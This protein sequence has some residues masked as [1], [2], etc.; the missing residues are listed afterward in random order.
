MFAI[1]YENLNNRET[2]FDAGW[3]FSSDDTVGDTDA[4]ARDA[5]WRAVTIPHDWSVED[6]SSGRVENDG[7]AP[8]PALWSV[9]GVPDK[10]GPFDRALSAGRRNSGWTVGGVGWY[11]K[12]F[13]HP[14]P[15]TSSRIAV[16][17]DGVAVR[18]DIWINGV[19]LGGHAN[20]YTPQS[21]DL[22]PYLTTDS[23][24]VII[25]R[26]RNEGDTSRWYVGSGIYRHVW[27]T[28]TDPLHLP[29]GGVY[30]T[31]PTAHPDLSV[32]Q[33][34]VE[35]RND[36]SVGAAAAIR[37]T[38]TRP[39]GTEAGR[40]HSDP[41]QVTAATTAGF[42]VTIPVTH[43]Q[44]WSPDQPHLYR[45]R[46]EIIADEGQV[47]DATESSFGIRSITLDGSGMRINGREIVLRG[48][49][50]HHDHGALGA[51][52]LARSEERRVARLKEVGFNAI[53]ASHNPFDPAFYRAC[54]RLGMLVVDEYSDVWDTPKTPEDYS[55]D[56]WDSWRE[57]LD[58]LVRRDRNHPSVF[59]W[60]IGNEIQSERTV[61]IQAMLVSRVRELDPT[62]P[63]TQGGSS[64]YGFGIGFMGPDDPSWKLLDVG[65]THYLH[66]LEDITSRYPDRAFFSSE[67]FAATMHDDWALVTD[68]PA[69]FGDFAWTGWDHL[70]EA[71]VGQPWLQEV[72]GPQ[73]DEDMENIGKQSLGSGDFPWYLSGCS[74]L[75][76]LGHRRAQSYYRSV[77]W[78]DSDLELAVQRPTPTGE[79][80]VAFSWAWFDELRS[81]T[82]GVLGQLMTVRAYTTG[83]SVTLTLNGATVGTQ[84]LAPSDKRIATFTVP[85]APGELIATASRDGQ[86]IAQQR[87]ATVG[88]PTALRLTPETS[89]VRATPDDVGYL[90]I[91][92]V[93]AQGA[94]VPDAVIPLTVAVSG[95]GTL[96]AIANGNPRDVDSFQGPHRHTYQGVAQVIVRPGDKSG[97]VRVSVTADRLTGATVEIPV[98][99]P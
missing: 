69:M 90:T 58:A 42:A 93:D 7:R 8:E 19:H 83:D 18:S 80:Q 55:S 71:G 38:V 40:A 88:A 13:P 97:V 77:V 34:A 1:D 23:D 86:Q 46:T 79:E 89:A 68:T 62:R 92:V 64:G 75:D 24:N 98:Y 82:W 37:C 36:R 35:V 76:I 43:P 78:G 57:D 66:D 41:K 20:P 5:T 87:L 61:E 9:A 70:G 96:A 32:V 51:V 44:L 33:I 6:R 21:W 72:G 56:F 3:L 26:A 25:V 67:S 17:F 59:L 81:W 84:H 74:D 22:T 2:S 47:V 85:Y 12:T 28:V 45:V 99:S 39:D 4:P 63:I 60:S 29:D 14:S 54:D 16:R 73:P 15:A 65:D 53:R 30:V 52:A 10:A 49:N 27:L 50:I 95:A 91:E 31:T 94:R 11:R 48:A